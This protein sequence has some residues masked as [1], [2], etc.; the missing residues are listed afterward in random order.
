M[1]NPWIVVVGVVADERHNGVTA[2]PKEKFYVPHTQWHVSTGGNL[3]R[4]VFLVA[5]TT[6]DPLSVAAPI[7]REI[8][9]LDPNLPVAN[10]RPMTDVVDTAL[11]TPRLTGFLMGAFAAVA[12][13]LAAVGLYGVLA[14]LVS[15]RTAEIGIRLAVGADRSEVVRMVLGQGL[16]LTGLGLV[17]GVAAALALTRM[18][19][20]MLYEVTPG[21]PWT[22]VSVIL[23]LLVMSVLASSLPALRASRVDPL[24]ALRTE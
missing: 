19:G 2:A 6:G 20:G 12:L 8:R 9:E 4:G 21:D 24:V 5:R 13:A 14:Y 18:M 1:Q 10:V 11:A 7:R 15:R 23:V 16:R 17:I 3:V 22:Y